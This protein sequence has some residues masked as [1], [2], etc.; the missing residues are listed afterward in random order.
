MRYA[1][2]YDLLDPFIQSRQWAQMTEGQKITYGCLCNHF[3]TTLRLLYRMIDPFQK[4]SFLY[5]DVSNY[6]SGHLQIPHVDMHLDSYKDF[7]VKL[8]FM[9]LT[10]RGMFLEVWPPDKGEGQLVF[11]KYGT[12]FYQ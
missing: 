7:E 9:P 4:F 6:T 2:F 8:A 11:I 3:K 12:V 1:P 10:S 5:T